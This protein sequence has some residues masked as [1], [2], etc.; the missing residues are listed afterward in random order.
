MPP[1]S[2]L[3]LRGNRITKLHSTSTTRYLK[4]SIGWPYLQ[5]T[6]T[7]YL[8]I[9]SQRMTKLETFPRPRPQHAFH[10]LIG[11]KHNANTG[12]DLVVLWKN[13]P[14]QT[15]KT[16]FRDNFLKCPRKTMFVNLGLP[17]SSFQLHSPPHQIN[18]KGCCTK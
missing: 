15:K 18:R 3:S 4:L 5:C 7:M 9:V 16:L 11:H 12:N 13:P 8:K 2:Q 6:T 14:I 17:P 1:S 10:K